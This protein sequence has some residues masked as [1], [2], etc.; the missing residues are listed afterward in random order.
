MKSNRLKFIG[1]A[2]VVTLLVAITAVSE[3]AGRHGRWGGHDGMFGDAGFGFMIHRLDLTDAQRAQAKQI[4][5]NGKSA[6]QPLMQQMRQNR[7]QERQLVEAASFDQAQ[8]QS[9]AAQQAQTIAQMSVEKMR[10]E[11]Q[12]YQIL[13]PD[14]KTKLNAILDKRAERFQ[15]HQQNQ[16]QPDQQQQPLNQ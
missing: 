2:L 5:T 12:L 15:Q 9:L 3:T 11:S 8:A 13:T 1:A 10:V 4:M 14:Q 7:A 6:F 16:Q